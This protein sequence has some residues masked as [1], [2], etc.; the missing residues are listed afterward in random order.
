MRERRYDLVLESPMGERSG[1]LRLRLQD[2]VVTGVLTLLG[3]ENEVA[4]TVGGAGELRLVHPLRSSRSTFSC[5]SVLRERDGGL[6][7]RVRTEW[8]SWSCRGT[9][10][11]AE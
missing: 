6:F 1:T 3:Y 10:S 11:S 7:G 8:G 9:L 4:G 5:E 2:G